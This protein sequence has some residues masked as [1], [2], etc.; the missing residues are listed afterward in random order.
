MDTTSSTKLNIKRIAELAGVSTSTVSR[1]L[2]RSGYVKT[3]V[4]E[5]VEEVIAQT[6]YIP[7]GVAKNLKSQ[8][9]NM[10][11]VILPRINSFA[12]SEITAGIA[13]RLAAQGYMTILANSANNPDSEL[14]YIDV[15]KSH[16]VCGVL[17]LATIITPQHEERMNGLGV[18]VVV[19]GQDASRLGFPSVVQDERQATQELTGYL[20][21]SG[22]RR[23]GLIGV[24]EWDQQVG[25][26]RK[27]GFLDAMAAAGLACREEDMVNGG[28]DLADGIRGADQL[29]TAGGGPTAILAV[30]DRLAIGAMSRLLERRI[31]VPGAVS[32][33]GV[34][35]IDVASVYTPK[36][37]TVHFDFFGTGAAAADMLVRRMRGKPLPAL[38]TVMPFS[39]CIR[40][41]V[42]QRG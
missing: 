13:S 29:I 26:E 4:R 33:A 35:D 28:F 5:R 18:P 41:S 3:D 27:N 20:I 9:T 24:G 17:I 2:N 19:V 30:T 32:V 36:L 16:R 39:L 34:G 37:T 10:V 21:R 1:V 42:V 40:D 7:S 23:I 15:F 25:C 22:H 8:R 14:N 38:R 12:S 31:P 6:G 11:G